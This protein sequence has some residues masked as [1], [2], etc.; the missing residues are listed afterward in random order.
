MSHFHF[1][2]SHYSEM[3][4]NTLS[5]ESWTNYNFYTYRKESRGQVSR[6]QESRH[7]GILLS[8]WAAAEPCW[9]HCQAYNSTHFPSRSLPFPRRTLS[10]HWT[11][12][13]PN[14]P[15]CSAASA[16]CQSLPHPLEI[17][18]WLENCH[19][20]HPVRKNSSRKQCHSQDVSLAVAQY[21]YDHFGWLIRQKYH[22]YPS[23]HNLLQ[24]P[25]QFPHLKH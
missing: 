6:G 14:V 12:N 9:C 19:D 3:I 4:S 20:N 2:S 13:Q 25:Y 16:A 24:I 11:E 5:Q 22:N 23:N 17:E 21:T 18:N 8:T 10:S 15:L 7:T 1:M